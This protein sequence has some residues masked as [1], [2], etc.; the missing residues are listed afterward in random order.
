M[1][2]LS[3]CHGTPAHLPAGAVRA[4]RRRAWAGWAL[5]LIAL[6]PLLAPLAPAW[7]A[8]QGATLSPAEVEQLAKR[9]RPS[10]VTVVA[11]R[12]VTHKATAK[13]PA[14]KRTH[15]RV[16]SGVA[17]EKDGI[18]TTASVVIGAQ[19]VLVVTDNGIQVAAQVVGF[20]P[21]MNVALLRVPGLTL[22]PVR[23]AS[24]KPELGDPVVALGSSYR[25][26][27]TQSLGRI[28][29]RF[30]EPRSSLLQLTNEV[31]PGNSGGAAL[32]ARGELVGLVQGEL[33]TPE[34]PGQRDGR[35][36]RPGGMSFVIPVEDI[37][38]VYNDLKGSGRVRH[39]F[40]GVSTRAAFVDSDTQPG[41]RVPI[42]ALVEA[43]QPGGPAA[44]MG[45]VKGDLIV[46]FDGERVEYPTQLARWVAQTRPNQ[47]V[48]LVWVHDELQRDGQAALGESPT[49]IPSWMQADSDTQPV[50]TAPRVDDLQ[51]QID[52]LSREL[53]RL[54]GADSS[55]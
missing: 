30:L 10:M 53:K 37:Q 22:S 15:N 8:A 54:K 48:R 34:A 52:K 36:R 39:G 41:L 25:A 19:R 1:T 7:A 33:G 46:A 35:E 32:D 2:N 38:R 21:V 14:G 3:R 17:I 4:G 13:E 16:G 47:T 12:T 43:V 26:A 31:Y 50:A 44:R 28:A 42:G 23:F 45:L 40:L 51:Q 55:R 20:D 27:P 18:L 9:T 29:Y 11:Q 6:W 5:L 49:V 24:R